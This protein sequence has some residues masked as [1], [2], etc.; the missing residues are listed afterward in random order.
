MTGRDCVK[1]C[2]QV[3]TPYCTAHRIASCARN[4]KH[5]PLVPTTFRS[6]PR[7]Y[8]EGDTTLRMANEEK[9]CPLF[10]F[11]LPSYP[12]SN[13]R[14]SPPHLNGDEIT[15]GKN[16]PRSANSAQMVIYARLRGCAKYLDQTPADCSSRR[17][18]DRFE[19]VHG[20]RMLGRINQMSGEI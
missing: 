19:I 1:F 18:S 15:R 11:P 3:A 10:S 6:Y 7:A 5:S 20:E 12:A 14:V 16:S 13:R 9:S 17:V 2:A 4:R 8:R